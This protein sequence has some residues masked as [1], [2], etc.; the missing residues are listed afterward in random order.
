MKIILTLLLFAFSAMPSFAQSANCTVNPASCLTPPQP[1]GCPSTH[2]WT[3]AGSG[4][5]HCA[6]T[7]ISCGWGYRM[8]RDN[9]GNA[10]CVANTCPSNQQL[11]ADGVSCACPSGTTWNGSSCV[12][13]APTPQPPATVTCEE[14]Q[15]NIV[16]SFSCY[17]PAKTIIWGPMGPTSDSCGP[18]YLYY[19]KYYTC[20]SGPYGPQHTYNGPYQDTTYACGC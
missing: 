19:T 2:Y 10:I 1:K 3:T 13:M 4:L 14:K 8:E 12:D 17:G 9:L 16:T 6:L 20:P 7:S 15:E 11:Q 18:N 5:A